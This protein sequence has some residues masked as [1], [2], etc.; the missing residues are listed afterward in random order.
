[1]MNPQEAPSSSSLADSMLEAFGKMSSD[2]LGVPRPGDDDF[3]VMG[4]SSQYA[5]WIN[6]LKDLASGD[7]SNVMRAFRYAD[8]TEEQRHLVIQMFEVGRRQEAATCANRVG[9]LNELQLMLELLQIYQQ[10]G[11]FPDD[12]RFD[13]ALGSQMAI[14]KTE[15]RALETLHRDPYLWIVQ[16]QAEGKEIP[17]EEL[18]ALASKNGA[19]KNGANGG[20]V[21]MDAYQKHVSE[22]IAAKT[23]VLSAEIEIVRAKI[24]REERDGVAVDFTLMKSIYDSHTDG[25][26]GTTMEALFRSMPSGFRW[27]YTY[28]ISTNKSNI[29]QHEE[30]LI[31]KVVSQAQGNVLSK[32]RQQGRRRRRQYSDYDEGQDYF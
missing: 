26:T 24:A 20:I 12:E 18:D 13:F 5:P 25:I 16:Q 4:E 14:T 30:A 9:K 15:M 7:M 28:L 19:S 32:D 22:Y 6:L 8:I 31:A 23:A 1:M 17:K 2:E 11:E 27:G 3:M 29:D 10:T 21:D